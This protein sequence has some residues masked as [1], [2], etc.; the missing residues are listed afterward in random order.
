MKIP[1][2]IKNK[3]NPPVLT[4]DKWVIQS[5]AEFLG[6]APFKLKV[7]YEK[8]GRIISVVLKYDHPHVTAPSVKTYL[9]I[10]YLPFLENLKVDGC[11]FSVVPL[12]WALLNQVSNLSFVR[13]ENIPFSE[14]YR[15]GKGL[16]R[17]CFFSCGLEDIP[18]GLKSLNNL[19]VLEI[20]DMPLKIIPQ[21]VFSLSNLAYLFIS[22]CLLTEVPPDIGKLKNLWNLGLSGNL[23]KT[24]PKE[25]GLISKLECIWIGD[26]PIDQ[27]PKELIKKDSPSLDRVNYDGNSQMSFSQTISFLEEKKKFNPQKVVSLIESNADISTIKEIPFS[28]I[29]PHLDFILNKL[30]SVNNK[31]HKDFLRWLNTKTGIPIGSEQERFLKTNSGEKKKNSPNLR[32]L[33]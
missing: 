4:Y 27:I 15:V 31:S 26:N 5:K 6:D 17:L 19:E 3:K 12:N 22:N 11:D 30:Q 18:N 1:K 21:E 7:T 29:Q 2:K 33:L 25:V 28:Y 8:H 20:D 16:K 24:I 14:I 9:D 13:C 23:L 10:R 32:I